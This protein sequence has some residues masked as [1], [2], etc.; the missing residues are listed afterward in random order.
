MVKAAGKAS[1]PGEIRP[2]KVIVLPVR[3]AAGA[4]PVSV[5]LVGARSVA[6]L[7]VA[8]GVEAILRT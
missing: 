2:P 5:Q 7:D 8:A 4:L 1:P 3:A 6:L